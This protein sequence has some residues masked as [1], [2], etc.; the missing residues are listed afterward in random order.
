MKKLRAQESGFML[1]ELLMAILILAVGVIALLTVVDSSRRL[2]NVGEKQDVLVQVAQQQMEKILSL[3]YS[4][5]ALN[6]N[7]TCTTYSGDPNNSP[8]TNVSGCPS[9]PF[10]YTWSTGNTENMI[11]DTTNGQ[12]TP[13]TTQTT[14]TASGGTRLTLYIY[15]YVTA[16][17]DPTCSGC[18]TGSHSENFKRI[19]VAV[20]SSP[21]LTPNK[22]PITI[23]S[24]ASDPCV[25]ASSQNATCLVP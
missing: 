12:V 22:Q 5:I 19:T 25:A 9:G 23:S 8:N 11:V 18:A 20:T 15:S 14:T 2:T 7:P 4:Q 17:S 13:T 16:T 1:I 24:L 3:P 6:A 10:T 21:T